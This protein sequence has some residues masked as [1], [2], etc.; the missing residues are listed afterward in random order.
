MEIP[1]KKSAAS[2]LPL[3]NPAGR[4]KSINEGK[5]SKMRKDKS[6]PQNRAGIQLELFSR[7]V[8]PA[9]QPQGRTGRSVS[10][11]VELFSILE[12]QR[13][14]TLTLLDKIVDYGNLT[15]AYQQVK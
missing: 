4:L 12:K 15:Q 2:I 10:S 6:P 1:E 7:P 3:N 8:L 14:L 11:G 9:R 5:Q 13:T